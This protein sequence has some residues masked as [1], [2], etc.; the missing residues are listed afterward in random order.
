MERAAN[1]LPANRG[2]PLPEKL[3]GDE[4]AAPARAQ[5]AMPGRRVLFEQV[6]DALVRLLP[7]QRSR[8]APSAV[9]EGRLA[10]PEEAGDDRVDGGA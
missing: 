1:S 6:L 7:E 3:Q 10:L 5:P 4:L 9:V 2:G 8:P